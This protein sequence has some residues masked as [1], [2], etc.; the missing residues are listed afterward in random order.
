VGRSVTAP[1]RLLG[2]AD[3]LPIRLE[4]KRRSER[5]LRSFTP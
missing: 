3:I 1:Q 2:G 4:E 5:M